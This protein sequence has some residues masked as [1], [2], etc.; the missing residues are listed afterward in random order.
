MKNKIEISGFADE[1]AED[2]ETQISVV[3]KLGIS[4]IEMRGVNG[5][6]LVEHSLE[7]VKEI[8]KQLDKHGL[9]LSSV[10][11]PIGKIQITEDFEE[12]FELYKKTVE[13]AKIMETPYIRMFSFFIPTGET[14]E[15]YKEQVFERLQR[16]ADYA[17]K[18]NVVLLHENEKEIYGDN[19]LRCLEIMQQFYGEHFKAVFDFANFVQC[20]QDTKEAYELLKPYIAYIHIKDAKAD[21]GMVVPAGYGDGHVK[22]IL[23]TLLGSGYE[24]FLSLEPHLT[25]FTGFGSLEQ[26]GELENR[27]MSGEEAYTMAYT[28][29]KDIL[30]SLL[31]ED[32]EVHR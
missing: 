2:L 19:A 28:A 9:K 30:D 16:M 8:K 17:E 13:I 5:K 15:I 12:H 6:P 21:S 7:E 22:E 27:K 1:I 32:E 26:N 18:Q 3:K 24:G 25:E 20:R 4:Y 31:Q 23:K 10:G 11:S 29:L 14:P